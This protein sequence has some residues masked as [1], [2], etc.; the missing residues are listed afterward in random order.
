MAGGLGERLGYNGIK[1]ELPT[2]LASRVCY[3]ELYVQQILTLQALSN[4][5]AGVSEDDAAYRRIPL[6][7][8]TSD[9]THR[10]T[11]RLLRRRSYFGMDASQLTLM[12]Q[13]KVPALN[14]NEAR[15]A[16][17]DKYTLLTKPHGHGDVHTLLAG[18]GLA[19]KWAEEGRKYVCFFQDTNAACFE[20]MPRSLGAAVRSKCE[21]SCRVPRLT[22][23]G[24]PCGRG[25]RHI[26]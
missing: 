1:V 7:I 9:D 14:D 3:L 13:E 20:Y 5:A 8:M 21:V 10:A 6:A 17:V 19:K 12:K 16:M 2:T 15:F 18:M 24:E 26:G 4:K 25:T 23:G 11:E 22:Q